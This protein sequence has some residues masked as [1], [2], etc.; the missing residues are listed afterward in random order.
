MLPGLPRTMHP[1]HPIRQR[2]GDPIAGEHQ[3]LG[4]GQADTG[5]IRKRRQRQRLRRLPQ[6]G[7]QHPRRPAPTAAAPTSAAR[8]TTGIPSTTGATRTSISIGT[9]RIRGTSRTSRGSGPGIVTNSTGGIRRARP[10]SAVGSGNFGPG[11]RS[12][13][14]GSGFVGSGAVGTVARGAATSGRVVLPIG[15]T[16]ID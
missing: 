13:I 7:H 8:T 4:L 1:P 14:S 3:V 6:R 10:E 5:I 15:R 11:A 16:V 12:S 9:S 2:R